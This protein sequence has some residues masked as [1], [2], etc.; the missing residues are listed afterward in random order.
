MMIETRFIHL[1]AVTAWAEYFYITRHVPYHTEIAGLAHYPP[2]FLSYLLV[3][4]L[5]AFLAQGLQL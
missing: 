5:K 1:Q 3:T 2:R 4:S